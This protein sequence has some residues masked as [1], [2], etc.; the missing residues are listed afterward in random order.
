MLFCLKKCSPSLLLNDKI[1]C[2]L[3]TQ[4]HLQTIHNFS[5]VI[6]SIHTHHLYQNILVI[7]LLMCLCSILSQCLVR[8][9]LCMLKF[10]SFPRARSR[11]LCSSSHSQK[12]AFSFFNSHHTLYFSYW[13]YHM[14]VWTFALYLC[15]SLIFPGGL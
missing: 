2:W 5:S 1:Q 7:D 3:V 15:T 12:L 13:V 4:N 6:P 9:Q 14:L 8:S 11:F 10:Y